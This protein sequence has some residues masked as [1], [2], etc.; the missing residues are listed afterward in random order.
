MKYN[1][2]KAQIEVWEMKESLYE[3]IK[4]IPD[5]DKIEYI[6]KKVAATVNELNNAGKYGKKSNISE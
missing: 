4:N 3:E 5:K 1:I 6:K 2:S